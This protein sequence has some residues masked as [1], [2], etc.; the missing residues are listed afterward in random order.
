M[1]FLWCFSRVCSAPGDA[2]RVPRTGL[3]DRLSAGAE[4][5][6]NPSQTSA[7]LPRQ[8][9]ARCCAP[10]SEELCWPS[11][12]PKTDALFLIRGCR[13]DPELQ[14]P[15]SEGKRAFCPA[16]AWIWLL[17]PSHSMRFISPPVFPCG[18][19]GADGRAGS[20]D[21]IIIAVTYPLLTGGGEH[22]EPDVLPPP[23][24]SSHPHSELQDLCFPPAG[25]GCSLIAGGCTI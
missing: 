4:Q 25:S 16:L 9:P 5:S 14:N 24:G 18:S 6:H 7:R 21:G 11:T 20:A 1:Y 8:T 2:S 17:S 15:H 13:T 12:S 23:P 19:S 3:G 10:A 22:R